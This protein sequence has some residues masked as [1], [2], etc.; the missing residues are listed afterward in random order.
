M[1]EDAEER[2]SDLSPEMRRAMKKS[3]KNIIFWETFSDKVG[4][5]KVIV[6]ALGAIVGY[7]TGLLDFILAALAEMRGR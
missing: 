3:A 6:L 7:A 5:A 4:G 2:W 1:N